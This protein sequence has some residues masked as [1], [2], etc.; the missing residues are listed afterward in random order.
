MNALNRSLHARKVSVVF[1]GLTALEKVDLTI[2]PGEI[3]GL[4]G[5]NGAG[6]TTLINV[7]TRF[8]NPTEGDTLIDEQILDHYKPNEIR[9][10]GVARTF[11]SGRLFK[12]LEVIENL[13]IT[14]VGLGFN[15]AQS[16]AEAHRILRWIGIDSLSS[17]LAGS[18]TYTDE[19]RV[20]IGRAL[21][22]SPQYLLLDEPAAGMSA[23]EADELASLVRLI[24]RDIG[25]GVLLIEHNI[26]LVLNLCSHIY[27]L[28]SGRIVEQGNP[29][30]IRSSEIVQQAYMGSAG[31][32]A[33][34]I[35]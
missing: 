19:R 9:R 2:L 33:N 5:P 20:A 14:G 18:L 28:D 27:V 23:V 7:L 12:D 1:Q 30:H 31:G 8:Q 32:S 17:E 3:R 22:F 29:K 34:A 35:A 21:M 4:I 6:K 11:Q 15:R 10:M 25:C 26:G 16:V 24:A 13:E